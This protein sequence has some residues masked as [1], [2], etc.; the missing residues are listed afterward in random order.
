MEVWRFNI[1]LASFRCDDVDD[2]FIPFQCHG[3]IQCDD[4]KEHGLMTALSLFLFIPNKLCHL[5]FM[6][7]ICCVLIHVSILFISPKAPMPF[8]QQVGQFLH[9]HLESFRVTNIF[10]DD[11]EF[12]G[13]RSQ[14]GVQ[15]NSP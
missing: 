12:K 10:N 4:I 6:Y 3:K 13:G 1:H 5:S 8:Y 9:E 11:C 7:E 15:R 14:E 2:V